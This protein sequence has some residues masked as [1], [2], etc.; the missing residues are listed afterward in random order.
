[1]RTSIDPHGPRSFSVPDWRSAWLS[2][3]TSVSFMSMASSGWRRNMVSWA[4]L[5]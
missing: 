3:S 1:M 5:E 4:S 2:S